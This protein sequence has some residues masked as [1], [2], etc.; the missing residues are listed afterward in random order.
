MILADVWF[1]AL[2]V[3]W[4]GFLLLEGFD[5]G[6]GM[7]HGI[8]G[9]DEEGREEAIGT[10]APVWDGNEVWLVLAVGGTF[11]AFPSWYATMFSGFYPLVLLALVGL[12]VRGVS[13]EFRAHAESDR[14]RRVWS[15]TLTVGSLVTPLVLGIALADLLHGVP[16]DTAQEF[17]GG[18]GDLVA[19]YPV[20]TG[21][22][23]TLLCLVHGAVFLALKS[24]G[25]VR[26]RATRIAALLAP[27]GALAVV[28]FA[29][30]TRFGYGHGAPA[31]AVELAAVLAALAAAGLA[32]AGRWA[33]AFAA[34]TLT[35]AAVAGSLFAELAPRVMVS[36]L[37][38]AGDLTIANSS[39]SPYALTV[40]T[41]V[42][43]VL[44]PVVLL[45][46]GWTYVVFRRRLG[47]SGPAAHPPR[48]MPP[49]DEGPV[50][51]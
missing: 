22:T 23:I 6:V 12:I 7:L 20:V 38:P 16:I 43:A 46:Q 42:L 47:R 35:I 5:F 15:A 3:V 28:V 41:V 21:L 32:W 9:R 1:V 39:S 29:A 33:G 34:T 24:G 26:R 13:F 49:G 50:A 44:L 2:A 11:A 30:W 25:D 18:P 37:G 45:Y 36:S 8:V 17:V 40:M 48:A 27:F 19:P 4:V 51:P 10:I 14:S 31:A